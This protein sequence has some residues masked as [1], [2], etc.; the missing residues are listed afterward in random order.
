VAQVFSVAKELVKLSLSGDEKDPLTN[1][2]LQKLLY[3]AQAWS[4]VVR[5]S[6]L[7]SDDLQAWRWG[8]VVLAVHRKLP[9]GQGANQINP[10]TF[11]DAPNLQGDEAEFV[12][13]VWEAYNQFSALQL[14][15]MTHEELPWRKAWGDRPIDASGKDPISLDDLEEFFSKQALPASLAAYSHELRKRGEEAERK[16]AAMVP[17]DAGRLQAGARSLSRSASLVSAP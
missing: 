5:E 8:P 13:C 3:Y 6:E 9:D 4:L 15:R 11:D 7:F 2:R 1:L 17:L 16:L 12:K 10:D 14:S